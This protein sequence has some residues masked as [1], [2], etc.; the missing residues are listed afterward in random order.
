ML[1]LGADTSILDRYKVLERQD[2]KIDT[3]VIAPDVCGQRNKS[4]PWFWCY[5]PWGDRIV[6]T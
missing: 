3:V 6:R 2:L 4:L 5:A 1:D